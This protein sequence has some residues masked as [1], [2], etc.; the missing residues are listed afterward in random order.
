DNILLAVAQVFPKESSALQHARTM[1]AIAKV[2]LTPAVH[3]KPSELSGGMRQ[4][5]SVARALAMNPQVLLLDEPLS[6]LD[7]LTRANIQDEIVRI[8]DAERKTVVLITNDVD[9][10]L[11]MAD[12][13]IPLS[14]GPGACLGPSFTVDIPRPRDRKALN[15]DPRFRHLRAGVIE[16]LTGPGKRAG[17][18]AVTPKKVVTSAKDG[19]HLTDLSIG[20]LPLTDCAPFIVASEKGF[21]KKHG[22][23]VR[24]KRQSSWS[25]I[26]DALSDGQ[27][28]AAHLLFGIPVAA[29]LGLLGKSK[30]P[31]VIPWIASRNG[32]A[33]TLAKK[34]AGRANGDPS[35][36]KP[37]ADAAN[38]A[39]R[40]LTFAVTHPLGTHAMWLRYWLGAGGI[41]PDVDVTL[42]TVPPAAMVAG[43]RR[44]T[45]DGLC[46]GEPWNA[47]AVDEHVGFTAITSQEIWR[48][49]PEK[50]CAF[51]EAF[52]FEHPK[53]VQAVC[54]ALHEASVWLDEPVN[55]PAAAKMLSPA[56]YVN[57]PAAIIE[58]RLSGHTIY[59]D[60]RTRD[61]GDGGV[62]FSHR[63]ANYPQ[64]K[65]VTWWLTQL[66]RWGMAE[67]NVDYENI[68][69]RVARFDLYEHAVSTIGHL[70]AGEDRSSEM[71]FDG[72]VFDPANPAAYAAS[73]HVNTLPG[74]HAVPNTAGRP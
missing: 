44:E 21:F 12:R 5:V 15:H 27:L 4:R 35:Q 65:Y 18:K 51:T 38:A 45:L 16:W 50:V 46:V 26:T 20:F 55:R 3:K 67:A 56:H 58:K 30:Q 71:F 48:D 11:L 9:E 31:M 62:T 41:H 70:H 29:T 22:L 24:L 2:N 13:I 39:E 47:L 1:G 72:R 34:F 63:N 6:A 10:G 49:H 52:A 42:T 73:F 8:W 17:A 57:A 60:G 64:P 68:A 69:R 43:L 32:Q 74:E 14:A 54:R 33:I 7:A 61:F 28:H 59:G 25:Q 53:T 23:N 37:L 40:A 19:M 66:V 36:L